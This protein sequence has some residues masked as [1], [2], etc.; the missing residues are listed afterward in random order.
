[1]VLNRRAMVGMVLLAGLPLAARAQAEPVRVGIVLMHGKGGMPSQL[2]GEVA[3]LERQGVLVANLEMPWSKR[4]AYDVDVSAAE[5]EVVSALNA[6]RKQGAQKLFVA[7]HSQGG[8]FV[9][10]FAS[11]HAVDGVIAIAPGGNVASAVFREKLGESVALARR[12]VAQGQGDVP[13]GL[14]DFESSRGTNMVTTTP[15]VYLSWFDPEGAM[16]QA[17]AEQGMDPAIPVLF[18]APARDYPGLRSV[19]Q[20]MFDRL[21]RNPR[22]QLYEPDA[23][24][25]EAPAASLGVIATWTASVAG[26]R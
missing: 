23:S 21:P 2:V 25:M 16:N 22:N 12:L 8:L 6:L 26:A 14:T 24:H 10:Y 15:A 7:G 4:R 5:G 3:V 18:I 13:V 9:L 20:Q 1:M 17:K 11:R 19:K